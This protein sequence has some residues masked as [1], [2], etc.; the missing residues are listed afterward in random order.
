MSSQSGAY[1]AWRLGKRGRRGG[2][3]R[4]PLQLLMRGTPSRSYK[5]A[6]WRVC[7]RSHRD[8]PALSCPGALFGHAPTKRL[9]AKPAAH[10]GIC[11]PSHRAAP[12]GSWCRLQ[13]PTQSRTQG[14]GP[15][16]RL[17]QAREG[18]AERTGVVHVRVT[19]QPVDRWRE[20]PTRR[21]RPCK[22]GILYAE[23]KAWKQTKVDNAG[24]RS[25]WRA[26]GQPGSQSETASHR[27]MACEHR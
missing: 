13:L 25:H 5:T 24:T 8:L 1:M 16:N 4:E 20:K 21:D 2:G 27:M 22:C 17:K 3:C 23:H 10:S 9:E 19:P 6:H 14:T 12:S 11:R 7:K 15:A 18:M 26:L